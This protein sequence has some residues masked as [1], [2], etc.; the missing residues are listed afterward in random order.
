MHLWAI[1][2]GTGILVSDR[3]EEGVREVAVCYR[4]HGQKWRP[5]VSKTPA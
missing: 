1:W 3:V 4:I 5:W 2:S